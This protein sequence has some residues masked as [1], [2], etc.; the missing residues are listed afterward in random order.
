MERQAREYYSIYKR[1]NWHPGI[2]Q[3]NDCS[4]ITLAM[5]LRLQFKSHFSRQDS[6]STANTTAHAAERSEKKTSCAKLRGIKKN[7]A[8][9]NVIA[10]LG[11]RAANKV[12]PSTF[13]PHTHTYIEHS[14]YPQSAKLK[15]K[16]DE[17]K[18]KKLASLLHSQE[19]TV[20]RKSDYWS[21]S[22]LIISRGRILLEWISWRVASNRLRER[23]S[24]ESLAYRG[25]FVLLI[26]F[27]ENNLVE[28]WKKK[29]IQFLYAQSLVL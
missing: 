9:E 29:N 11:S 22:L 7:V 4:V 28:W 14:F 10:A 21:I 20:R 23:V 15:R 24:R 17:K 13:F 3:S 27:V 19:Y 2:R 18:R 25:T 8:W 1:Q 6:S 12:C 26:S 5:C 16:I